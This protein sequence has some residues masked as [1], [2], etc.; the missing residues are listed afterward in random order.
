MHALCCLIIIKNASKLSIAH[1][2]FKVTINKYVK[3]IH[4]FYDIL[5]H[6]M[7]IKEMD[8][9]TLLCEHNKKLVTKSNGCEPTNY[10]NK[11]HMVNV[12]KLFQSLRKYVVRNI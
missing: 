1:C 10:R 9:Q 8:A 12:F 2:L 5:K 6:F 3:S 7:F 4:H 11:S